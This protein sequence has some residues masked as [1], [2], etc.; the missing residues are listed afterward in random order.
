MSPKKPIKDTFGNI[1]MD[2]RTPFSVAV[3]EGLL[4]LGLVTLLAFLGVPHLSYIALAAAVL[5]LITAGITLL[6]YALRFSKVRRATEAAEQ[7]NTDI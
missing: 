3:A 7:L 6:C 4:L 5:Y 2:L 1:R